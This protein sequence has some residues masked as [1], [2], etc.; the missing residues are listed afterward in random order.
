MIKPDV[1][2]RTFMMKQE[3]VAYGGLMFEVF[4]KFLSEIRERKINIKER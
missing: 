1:D 4:E 3:L 2:I